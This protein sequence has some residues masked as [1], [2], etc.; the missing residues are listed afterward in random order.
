MSDF[1]RFQPQGFYGGDDGRES[2]LGYDP[3]YD[4]T[5]HY[6]HVSTVLAITAIASNFFLPVILPIALGSLSVVYAILSKGKR[7]TTSPEAKRGISIAIAAILLNV[8]LVV[9][10]LFTTYRSLQ[11]P[12][13]REEVNQ[14]LEQVYGVSLQEMLQDFD[15]TFGTDLTG[16]FGLDETPD[17]GSTEDS[18]EEDTAPDTGDTESL[19]IPGTATFALRAGDTAPLPLFEKEV[20]L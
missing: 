8:I 13:R 19:P 15:D 12:S 3:K 2:E 11:D 10:S 7:R 14:M 16:R 9:S 17:S 6:A 20:R 4:N 1:S 5:A 18:G